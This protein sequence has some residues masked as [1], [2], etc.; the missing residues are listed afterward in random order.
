MIE[1]NSFSQK[2]KYYDAK[3]TRDNPKWWSVDVTFESDLVVTYQTL[4]LNKEQ[5]P[6]LAIFKQPRLSVSEVTEEDWDTIVS[7]GSTST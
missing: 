7:L 4:K 1:F 2:N 6:N 3:A 5:L